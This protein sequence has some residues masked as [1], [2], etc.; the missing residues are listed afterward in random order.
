MWILRSNEITFALLG[1]TGCAYE[2]RNIMQFTSFKNTGMTMRRYRAELAKLT[3]SLYMLT[4]D[5]TR[6]LS[7]I[8]PMIIGLLSED[9]R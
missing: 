5:L 1:T 8:T 2:M 6:T 3:P 4:Q 9:A 7:M